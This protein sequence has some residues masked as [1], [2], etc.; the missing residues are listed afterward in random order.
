MLGPFN[1]KPISTLRISPI[2]LVEKS[3]HSWRLIT[4]LSYP[5]DNSVNDFIDEQLCTIKYAS[6]DKV[7][8]MLSSLGRSTQLAKID[9][10]QAFRLLIVNPADFDLLGI[11]FDGKYYIE[12]CLPMGCSISCALFEF[13]S[14]FLHWVVENKA[15]LSTLDHYLDDFKFAGAALTNDCQKIM[16]TFSLVS[17][18]LGV[19]LAENE[20]EGQKTK[21]IFLGLEIDAVLMKVKFPGDKLNKLRLGIQYILEHKKMKFKELES[22]VGLMA[23]CAQAIP[24]ARAF[25]RRFYDLISEVRVKKSYYYVRINQEIKSD[26]EVWLEFLKFLMG[27]VIFQRII[28]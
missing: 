5:K 23:F 4:H 2:G 15:S 17:K 25:I 28:G 21:I 13:F 14:T 12:K 27:S 18:E 16:D 22:I 7:L 11:K 1:H 3:D 19:P 20:T 24:S 6:F 26:A 9:I 10:R 8:D